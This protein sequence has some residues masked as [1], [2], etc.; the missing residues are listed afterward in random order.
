MN[1]C[2]VMIHQNRQQKFELYVVTYYAL[3]SFAENLKYDYSKFKNRY[4]QRGTA[5]D[6]PI[7]VQ[8]RAICLT[9]CFRYYFYYVSYYS[10]FFS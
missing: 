1:G 7:L 3:F 8:N 2:Y 4:P 6:V 5:L 9:E 10:I